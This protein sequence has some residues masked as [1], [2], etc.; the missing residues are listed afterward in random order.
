MLKLCLKELKV[1]KEHQTS[2]QVFLRHDDIS[3]PWGSTS[4][5]NF[6]LLHFSNMFIA[7]TKFAV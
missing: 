4:D 1:A 2:S 7:L 6:I 5:S 3:R